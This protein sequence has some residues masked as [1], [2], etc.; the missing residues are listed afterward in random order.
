M[1]ESFNKYNKYISKIWF[2]NK[3]LRFT[4]YV[5]SLFRIF[6][7]ALKLLACK[8]NLADVNELQNRA[9]FMSAFIESLM[10]QFVKM[11][12]RPVIYKI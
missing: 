7:L 8:W 10:P 3:W 12:N 9:R 6:T 11:C 1:F 2:R 5:M 4:Q